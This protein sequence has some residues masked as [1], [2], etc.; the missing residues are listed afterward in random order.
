MFLNL[1][2]KH[3][4][5]GSIAHIEKKQGKLTCESNFLENPN[6]KRQKFSQ[7]ERIKYVFSTAS[8]F[9]FATV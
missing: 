5:E 3:I 7:S 2:S 4:T 1:K 6:I 9:R 8:S